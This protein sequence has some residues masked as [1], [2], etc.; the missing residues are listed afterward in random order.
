MDDSRDIR[1]A[2]A[3]KAFVITP[4]VAKVLRY[5]DRCRDLSD[6]DSEPTCMMVYGSH[7]VGKTAIIKKYLKQNEGDSDTEGDTIPV[8]H[9]EMPDNA[10]PVDAARELL[11]QMED[12]LALYDTNLARLTK[13]IVELI[14]LLGV[15]LIII[16]EF[17][18]L[19]DESS[20]KILTQV[21]N[22]LKGI[23]NKSKC[24]IVLFGMP[25]SKLV[26][27]A[28]SQL[29]SRFSI[30]F[31]LRPFNYQEGEGTFKTFL[32]HLDE[33]LPFEKQTGLAK[34]GLQEKLYAFSQGNMRSLRD[35]IYQASIE[36]IDNHHESITKDD[37]LFASQLTSGNKP[38]FWKNP[39]I[40]GVKVTKEMLRSPPRSIGWED[41][42]QQ[43]NSRKKK[44]K[45]RPD[46]FDK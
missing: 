18:H 9:I 13:R 46:F 42:Y 40:E 45:G 41:Y 22:W 5:M 28:N 17:Q 14:P 10:K 3:K 29:H 32:Q 19:V 6:M 35:L 26:L 24:P 31:N 34:E 2:K 36:A 1:V 23:L 44:G 38:T 37:F 16:D 15:K 11:L 25:Y 33:A 43:N 4:S 27:Q 21:G 30:Q 20:N 7:G 39:F 12:P 8:I